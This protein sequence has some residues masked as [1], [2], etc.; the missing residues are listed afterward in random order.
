METALRSVVTSEAQSRDSN[1]RALTTPAPVMAWVSQPATESA[2]LLVSAVTV[3]VLREVD[4]E[5]VRA[6]PVGAVSDEVAV[7]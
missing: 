2:L 4:V 6:V 1:F 7:P 5:L 3:V